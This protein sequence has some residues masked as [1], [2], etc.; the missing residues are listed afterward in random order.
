M[1]VIEN[2]FFAMELGEDCIVKSLILKSNGEQCIAPDNEMALFSL[3]QERPYNNEIKLMNPNKRTTF[4]ANRVRR[5]GDKL[6][7]GFEIIAFEAVVEVKQKDDYVAFTLV[8][9]IIPEDAY[10]VGCQIIDPAPISEF[11]LMQLPVAK[12]ERFG[13]WLNVNWDDNVA[14]NVLSTCPHTFIDSENRKD[15]YIMY[16][17]AERKVKLLGTGAALIVAPPDKLLD[18]IESV[19]DDYDLPHGVKSRRSDEIDASIFWTANLNPSNVDEHIEYAKKGGFKRMLIY[20]SVFFKET[21]SYTRTGDY[22]IREDYYPNGLEDIKA[23][24]KKIKDAGIVP[25]I[26]FLHSHIG[27]NSRYVTPVADHRL[28]LTRYFT[29][30]KPLGTED[31]VIYVEQNPEGVP[32][33]S[34]FQVLKFGG[35]LIH[36]DSYTTERPYCFKNCKRGYYETNI[37]P[38]DIGTI[39]GVLDLS[40]FGDGSVYIDE[41]T[42]LQDEVAEKIARVYN[43]GLEFIYFDGSEGTN[44]PFE[45]NVPYAQYRVYKKFDK[46]PLFCE[47]AAKAHFGW[48]MLSGGNAFDVFPADVFKEKLAEFPLSAAPKMANNF[49]RLNFGWWEFDEVVQPDMYEYGASKAAAYDGAVT[50]QVRLH[51]TVN[52]PRKDDALEVLYRWEDI[53][54]KKWLTQE[55]KEA[56]KDP[57]QEHILLVNESGEYELVPYFRIKKAAKENK[58]LS[59]FYFERLGKTYVVCWHTEGSGKLLLPF[60]SA[61]FSYEEQLGAGQVEVEKTSEGIIIPVSGRKYFSS[62]VPKEKL[63]ETFENAAFVE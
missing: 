52:C 50:V 7:V 14:I 59:A 12:R 47:G 60:D 18:C 17:Q 20:Y 9:F 34:K 55:Q 36:Y 62:A 39:G 54:G 24:L 28:N 29:L 22:D 49:T 57:N 32:L 48:H 53:K 31:D 16:A 40:E 25:G 1:I 19:E 6:I 33:I 58:L 2:S 38:H 44:A 42:S 37:V 46:E 41:T 23:L 21:G 4:A 45:I 51:H 3:T 56:L 5:D 10:G 63:I 35:E 26:H 43:A 61:D 13:K 30:A 11:R 15:C 8:E 27:V